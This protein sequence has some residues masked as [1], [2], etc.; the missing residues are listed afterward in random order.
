M[1]ATMRIDLH[2]RG[3]GM[4]R[5][6]AAIVA[7]VVGAGFLTVLTGPSVPAIAAVSGSQF[8][9]A[10]IISDA[11]FFN[12]AS[13][14]EADVQG[15][16]ASKTPSCPANNGVPCL[17]SYTETT[18]SRA[19]V[20]PGHC[21]AYNGAVNE[22]A[23]RIITKVA[24]A[25]GIN[26]QVLLATLQKEQGLITATSPSTRQYRVAMGFGCPDT[27][28]CDTQYYG[29][30]NQV[31]KAAWQFRQYTIDPGYWRYR[32]GPTAVQFHP[33]AAC[34]STTVRIVNQATANLYNYTPYQ[35]NSASLANIRGSGDAC[36]SYGNRNFWVYFNEWF[37][38]STIP[39]SPIG[40]L[41][42]VTGVAKGL[43]LEGW[44]LDPET[45]A[46]I[47]VH[48][49]RDGGWAGE[50]I[51]NSQRSDVGAAYPSYGANHGLSVFI[52]APVGEHEVCLYAINVGA[53]YSNPLIGCRTAATP[54]VPPAGNFESAILD[55][56]TAVLTGWTV[57]LDTASPVQVHIYV[58]GRWGG[59]GVA[60]V[61][62]PDV[63]RAY[64]AYGAG[65]GFS[66]PIVISGGTSSTCVFAIDVG[67]VENAP[68]GCRTLTRPSFVPEGNF[69]SAVSGVGAATVT[70]W[71][72]DR[73]VTTA[74]TVHAY[75][76]GR[77]GGSF[78]AD[79]PRA[80]VG[81][82][83]PEQ[84]SDHGF[85]AS[86]PVRPGNNTVCLFAINIESG[87]SNTPLGCR[88]VTS[89]SALPVGSLDSVSRNFD[90]TATVRGWA[91]DPDTPAPISVHIYASGRWADAFTADTVRQDVAVAYP[92]AGAAH[93]FW[94]TATVPAGAG[95]LCVY[96][97]NAGG[98]GP[99]PLIG[100][101]PIL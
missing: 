36:S 56:R 78:V 45:E 33:N 97:I 30:Y 6:R 95:E 55:G 28:P 94:I 8:D 57:D 46:P 19:A 74:V 9:P 84:G 81:R 31:Y 12:S 29:F 53:G 54:S 38:P 68:L 66:I 51:A 88:V 44:A 7:L 37:G 40:A 1:I 70:G 82:V 85:S 22:S 5:M 75:V 14:T 67:G 16:L 64:P 3:V 71:A 83:F 4:K 92:A 61:S 39:V 80:D 62:R 47:T 27:A 21:A 90:G 76:D 17:K 63:G 10:N 49:Y 18:V 69:E 72:I 23:S 24:Q 2:P 50:F 15:F 41:D 32:V 77:W 13:M 60:N 100:C 20:R 26:P 11:N 42:S 59:S 96:A 65:H 52:P 93:G 98:G 89:V 87:S 48:V 99:N 25:C 58:N 86:V 73:D 91:L 79:R 43:Q 35:P 34:G 101:L